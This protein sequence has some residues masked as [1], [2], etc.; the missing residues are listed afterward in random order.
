MIWIEDSVESN[1][2]DRKKVMHMAE[3]NRR[4]NCLEKREALKCDMTLSMA[5]IDDVLELIAT[6]Q[7]PDMRF[8][9]LECSLFER[10]TMKLNIQY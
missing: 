7:W 6:K 10:I 5:E 2:V 4:A 8:S 3:I 1:N 9:D